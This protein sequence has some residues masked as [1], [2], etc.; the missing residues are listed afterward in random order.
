[1]FF[2]NCPK[3]RRSFIIQPSRGLPF[4]VRDA[5]LPGMGISFDERMARY[6]FQR[7][8]VHSSAFIAPGASVVGHV[9]LEEEASVW[10]QA[11]L[12]ADIQ[13]IH[14]GPRSNIQDGAVVHLDDD[15]PTVVGELVTVGHKA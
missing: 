7:P 10:Y 12:R 2:E 6:L 4:G 1:R 8:S 9:T 15:H 13:R 14:I 11:V 5:T 3:K